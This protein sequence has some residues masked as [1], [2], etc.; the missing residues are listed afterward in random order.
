MRI[1]FAILISS[2][3]FAAGHSYGVPVWPTILAHGALYSVLVYQ[4]RSFLPAMLCHAMHNGW[5]D[6]NHIA[7]LQGAFSPS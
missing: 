7:I 4:T 6:Y 2:L 1:P 3:L 5:T